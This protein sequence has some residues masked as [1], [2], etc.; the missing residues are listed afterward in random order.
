MF[1]IIFFLEDTH[2]DIHRD[3]CLKH[4]QVARRCGDVTPAD[5][6]MNTRT[7]VIRE[8][9]YPVCQPTSTQ[10]FYGGFSGNGGAC[11]EVKIVCI[12]AE[13]GFDQLGLSRTAGVAIP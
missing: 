9:F 1:I 11:D 3:A 4:R 10:N 8:N 6:A 7:V 5:A 13:R 12:P 2:H